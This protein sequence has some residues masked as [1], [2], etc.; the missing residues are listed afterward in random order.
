MLQSAP[1]SH[2]PVAVL[3]AVLMAAFRETEIDR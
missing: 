1:T 3:I 2:G